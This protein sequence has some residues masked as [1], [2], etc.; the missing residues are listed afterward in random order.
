MG[1]MQLLKKPAQDRLPRVLHAME[2]LIMNEQV[3]HLERDQ[4]LDSEY[5]HIREAVR[6]ARMLALKRKID[7]DLAGTVAA[8]QNI[9]RIVTGKDEG[10]AEAGYLPAKS[11]LKKLSCFSEKEIEQVAVAVRN[12]SR[13]E[14]IDAPLDELAKDADIYARYCQGQQFS[15]SRDLARFNRLRV[16]LEF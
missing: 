2:T 15:Q 7:I 11:L 8:V 4:G 16:E 3:K 12:Q 6:Y 9:G 14:E 1:L 5:D 10:H 13:K